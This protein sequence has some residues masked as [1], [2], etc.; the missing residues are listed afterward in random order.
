ML[1]PFF[2]KRVSCSHDPKVAPPFAL[3][4]RLTVSSRSFQF[5][6]FSIRRGHLIGNG[7]RTAQWQTK[8][9]KLRL[10]TLNVLEMLK[11]L[12]RSHW[13]EEVPSILEA[14]RILTVLDESI[15]I[16][17]CVLGHSVDRKYEQKTYALLRSNIFLSTLL[18]SNS[19]LTCVTLTLIKIGSVL[20]SNG[21]SPPS[22]K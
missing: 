5:L 1:I 9:G 16:E 11:Q 20:I 17:I 8:S 12:L 6:T 3:C 7:A 4:Y 19:L 10:E 21:Y 22:Y 2:G 14:H 15:E 13:D 18:G